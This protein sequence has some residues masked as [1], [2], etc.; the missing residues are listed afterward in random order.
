[1]A[2]YQIMGVEHREGTSKKTGRPYN[3]DVLHVVAAAPSRNPNVVGN[4]VDTIPIGRES[5]ILTATPKPGE[6]YEISFNRAGFVEEA[7]AVE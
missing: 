5:G 3:M 2:R 7:Y 6:Y 1:M 4:T